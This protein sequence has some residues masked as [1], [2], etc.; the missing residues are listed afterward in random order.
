MSITGFHCLA[1]LNIGA[2]A[3]NLRVLSQSEPLWAQGGEPLGGFF[4]YLFFLTKADKSSEP[5]DLYATK[6]SRGI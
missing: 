3:N 4:P 2:C 5:V 1:L 6:T